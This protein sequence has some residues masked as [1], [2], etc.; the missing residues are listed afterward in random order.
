VV[1]EKKAFN[2]AGRVRRRNMKC[3][4]EPL[5]PFGGMFQTPPI[6]F[7]R[8]PRQEAQTVMS[9][10]LETFMAKAIIVSAALSPQS[11]D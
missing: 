8:R 9:R 1:F 11:L 5:T 3:I 2:S 4:S 10:P 7:C 6:S